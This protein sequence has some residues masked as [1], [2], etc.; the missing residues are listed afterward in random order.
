MENYL[1]NVLNMEFCKIPNFGTVT[2]KTSNFQ[3]P[4]QPLWFREKSPLQTKEISANIPAKH[5]DSKIFCRTD[6]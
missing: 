1:F 2:M 5:Q 3:L 4:W 6:K